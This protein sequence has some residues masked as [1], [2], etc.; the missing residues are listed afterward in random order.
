VFVIGRAEAT[1]HEAAVASFIERPDEPMLARLALEIL[2]SWWGHTSKYRADVLRFVN[3]V[4]WDLEDGGYVRQIAIS[5]AGEHV[6]R[7]E[8]SDLLRALITVFDST[9]AP[10]LDREIA[11]HA[12]QRAAGVEWNKIRGAGIP[13]WRLNV[14]HRTLESLRRRLTKS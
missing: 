13:D 3:G 11:Y 2:C 14:D 1:A 4:D 9:D 7:H 5:A 8:D 10:D 6:R 12:L